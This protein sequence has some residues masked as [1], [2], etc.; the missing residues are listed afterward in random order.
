VGHFI[1]SGM[2]GWL[3]LIITKFIGESPG[4]TSVKGMFTD[5]AKLQIKE[6]FNSILFLIAP[7]I[8]WVAFSLF[9]FLL[10]KDKLYIGITLFVLCIIFFSMFGGST[11]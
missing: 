9:A 3:F 5:V 2:A 4:Y 11:V 7:S 8:F 10:D 1:C 6:L